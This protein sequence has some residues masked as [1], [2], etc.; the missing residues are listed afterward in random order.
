MAGTGGERITNTFCF[1]HHAI[2]VPEIIT[3]DRNIDATSR[4]TAAIAGI[5]DAPPNKMEAIQFLCTLLLGKVL[6]LLPPPSPSILPPPPPPSPVVDKDEPVIICNPQLV[7]PALPTHN[8]NTNNINSN[9]NTPAIVEDN[10]NNNSLIPSQW[11][12]PPCHHLICPLKNRPLTR[13]QLR[14]LST[15]LINRGIMEELMPT[16]ALCTCPPSPCRG[17]AF[18]TEC[19]F[20]KTISLPSHSTVTFIGTIIDNNTGN[21]LEYQHLMKMDKHKKVWAH[22]F[23]NEIGQIFQGIRDVPGT[24]TCFFIPKSLV[25]SHKGPTYGRIC[26]NYQPQK[27]EKH[28]VRLT[29]GGNWIDYPGNKSTLMAN[30]TMAKLLIYSTISTPGAKFLGIDL[31]YFYLNTLM[32]NPEY[33]RLHLDIIPQKNHRPLQPTQHCH[34]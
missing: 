24:D 20:L 33:M 8:F 25:P 27:E 10:C 5:Q 31:A 21:V 23:D 29:I 18:A 3:T 34:S 13:N 30:L 16:P 17:Y 4:L 28:C 11:T 32:P 14:L 15:H 12:R 6:T 26:C 9:S 2:P 1:K 19:I 7:Q 22:G